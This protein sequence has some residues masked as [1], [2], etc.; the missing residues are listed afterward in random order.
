MLASVPYQQRNTLLQ[1]DQEAIRASQAKMA[2]RLGKENSGPLSPAGGFKPRTPFLERAS[3]LR[4]VLTEQTP[5]AIADSSPAE[6][7]MAQEA[8]MAAM[9]C[10]LE[11]KEACLA[12]GS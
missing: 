3:S 10:S 6:V 11:N 9:V 7:D 8:K 12:C 5:A 4:P 1:V 2:Q